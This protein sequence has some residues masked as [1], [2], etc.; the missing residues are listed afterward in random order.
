MNNASHGGNSFTENAVAAAGMLS[1]SNVESTKR[2]R[3]RPAP[4]DIYTCNKS[5]TCNQK[6]LE[7]AASSFLY[8][9][10]HPTSSSSSHRMHQ[11]PFNPIQSQFHLLVHT[12]VRHS[13]RVTSSSSTKRSTAA[14][15]TT[16]IIAATPPHSPRL[17]RGFSQWWCYVVLLC[18]LLLLP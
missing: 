9:P 8:S 17:I 2:K 1:G 11:C 5:S 6:T 7:P 15:T 12:L 3:P 14:K 16:N 4:A 10:H 18:C 13:N